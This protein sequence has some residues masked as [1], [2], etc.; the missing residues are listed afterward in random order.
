MHTFFFPRSRRH[1]G[2]Y[3]EFLPFLYVIDFGKETFQLVRASPVQL[4]CQLYLWNTSWGVNEFAEL[5]G[6]SFLPLELFADFHRKR[7][8]IAFD[9]LAL[10]CQRVFAYQYL[11]PLNDKWGSETMKWPP[12]CVARLYGTAKLSSLTLRPPQHPPWHKNP[13]FEKKDLTQQAKKTTVYQ[14][15]ENKIWFYSVCFLFLTFAVL[16]EL[17]TRIRY[18]LFESIYTHKLE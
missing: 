1:E 7:R 15:G 16:L 17:N 14:R 8:L 12:V 11:T 13:Y 4:Q 18:R 5:Q 2:E 6:F 9:R 10:L 3:I